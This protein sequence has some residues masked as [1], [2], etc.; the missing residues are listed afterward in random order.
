MGIW[1]FFLLLLFECKSD[2]PERE[3]NIFEEKFRN[4]EIF[5]KVNREFQME[6]EVNWHHGQKGLI[7]QG[8]FK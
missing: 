3:P 2:R 5:S 7:I 1:F 4:L 8:C 6:K